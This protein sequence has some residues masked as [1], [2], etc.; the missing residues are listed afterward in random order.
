MAF[1]ISPRQSLRCICTYKPCGSG[2]IP[3]LLPSPGLTGSMGGAFSLVLRGGG[4]VGSSPRRQLHC[5]QGC[6][7]IVGRGDLAHYRGG[8]R[9]KSSRGWKSEVDAEDAVTLETACLVLGCSGLLLGWCLLFI[10]RL[11]GPLQAC[12]LSQ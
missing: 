5:A 11:W 2:S 8:N 10:E 7:A 3:H 6:L 1:L 4:G 9:I 12:H